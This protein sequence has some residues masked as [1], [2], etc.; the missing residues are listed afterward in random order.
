MDYNAARIIRLNS[1]KLKEMETNRDS[2][3]MKDSSEKDG[4]IEAM[5]DYILS[6]TLRRASSRYKDDNKNILYGYCRE[7]LFKLLDIQ[8]YQDI[9]VN[10]VETWKQWNRIDLHAN[11]ELERN[12]N[13]EYHAILI[14][15]KAYTPVHDNQLRRYK[16]IFEDAYKGNLY[17]LHFVL[18]TC[19][20]EAP[21]EINQSCKE[22]GFECLPILELFPN[23]GIEDSESDLFNEFWLRYW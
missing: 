12:G 14:E 9:I 6:W 3:L 5:L 10:D 23:D 8:D 4:K 18:I 16:E 11:I 7:I 22:A 15:D 17:K 2:L 1:A 21:E 19:H 20:E 13:K